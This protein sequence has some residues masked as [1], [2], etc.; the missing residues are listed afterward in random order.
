MTPPLGFFDPLGLSNLVA[1]SVTFN[2]F[3]AYIIPK[4]ETFNLFGL[5]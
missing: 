5:I 2:L 1:E 4:P 3:G